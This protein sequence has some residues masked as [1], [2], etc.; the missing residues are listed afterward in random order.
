MRERRGLPFSLAASETPSARRTSCKGES[1]CFCFLFSMTFCR[2]PPHPFLT[3]QPPAGLRLRRRPLRCLQSNR[4][5][6][7]RGDCHRASPRQQRG[8]VRITPQPESGFLFSNRFFFRSLARPSNRSVACQAGDVAA[9]AAAVR[10]AGCH[11][12]GTEAGT[13]P[14]SAAPGSVVL[15]W[16][17]LVCWWSLREQPSI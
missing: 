2:L 6:F 3:R 9:A 10:A 14:G 8:C 17:N 15:R 4:C 12:T 5:R 16:P 13:S 1:V 7:S 11:L